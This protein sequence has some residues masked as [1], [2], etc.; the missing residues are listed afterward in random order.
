MIRTRL[1]AGLLLACTTINVGCRANLE[2]NP[3]IRARQLIYQ[4]ESLRHI[5]GNLG[6][7]L[8]T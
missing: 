5:P 6:T 8:G 1:M 3:D 4:S 7:H 2:S